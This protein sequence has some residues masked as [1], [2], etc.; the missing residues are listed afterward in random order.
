MP[1]GQQAD[2]HTVHHFLLADNYFSD[3]LTHPIELL[4][5]ELKSCVRLHA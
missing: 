3:F 2:E 5:G 4:G 1:A